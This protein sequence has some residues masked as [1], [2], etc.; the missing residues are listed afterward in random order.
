M[1]IG[2]LY[3]HLYMRVVVNKVKYF[4]LSKS[5]F[6]DKPTEQEPTS[7][8]MKVTSTLTR[9]DYVVIDFAR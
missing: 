9:I 5:L 1:Y 7:L 6:N 4:T 2:L 8:K 3:I